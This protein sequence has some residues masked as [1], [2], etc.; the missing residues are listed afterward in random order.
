MLGSN[1]TAAI[2]IQKEGEVYSV[3][4]VDLIG[5]VLYHRLKV[6]VNIN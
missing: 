6:A 2:G 5:D 3:A 1:N 4:V